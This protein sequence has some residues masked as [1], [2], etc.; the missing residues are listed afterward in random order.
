[1]AYKQRTKG[2][3][4]SNNAGSQNEGI[5]GSSPSRGTKK[6]SI[7]REFSNS[8]TEFAQLRQELVEEAVV[9]EPEYEVRKPNVMFPRL[10]ATEKPRL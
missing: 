4:I 8:F 3:A 9:R 2:E 7:K 5:I 6:A 1:L 10:F